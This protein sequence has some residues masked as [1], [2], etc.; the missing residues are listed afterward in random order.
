M[1]ALDLSTLKP[2]STGGDLKKAT[3]RPFIFLAPDKI[4]A[5]MPMDV[6]GGGVF[7]FPQGKRLARFA[8]Y[9]N[10]LKLTGNPNYVVIKPLANAPMGIFDLAKGTIVSGMN[11]ADVTLW[12]D[13]L[14]FELASGSVS[15]SKV[16][17]N[18]DDK[19]LHASPVEKI[20]IPVGSMSRLYAASISDDLHWLAAS[21][22]TRGAIWDLSSGERKIHV[23]GFRGAIVA[24]DGAAIGDFPKLDPINHSLVFLS[25]PT[26]EVTPLR[27]IPEKGSRQYGRFV[28]VR[29]S[30]KAPKVEKEKEKG[31]EG[32]KPPVNLAV[33]ESDDESLTHEVKFELRDVVN[34]KVIWTRE[35]RKEAPRYFFDDYSGRLIFYWDLGSEVG[36]ARLKED[37]A[38]LER[39]RQMGN[40]DDDYLVEVYDAFA[41]KSV[42]VLLLETGQ[43][44][45]DIES[46][47][48]E[49]DWLVLRDDNNRVL[50][51]SIN[52]GELR[53]RFFGAH[54]AMNPS[55]N[56][57]IVEN[58]PGELTLYDL[59]TGNAQARL[60][61]KTGAAFVRF[62]LDGKKLFVLTAGQV[63]HAFDMARLVTK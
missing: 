18:E 13:F 56:Q 3:R 12:N 8:L 49:G 15:V 26:N 32:D 36:K 11:K 27:E 1:L 58:Y 45:F 42:G 21:S 6:E 47:F 33:S 22:K 2:V 10:E 35:F 60:R 53:H 48:S 59:T 24:P 5:M 52:A 55:G 38:L 40:K 62:S 41:N 54:A 20:D 44:S 16:K 14:F 25:A 19:V 37:P 4:M 43:G 28:M 23:R 17:Y 31:K 46:G 30:F 61:F 51:Y 9:A 7:S 50:V 57:V 34:D 29:Q 63:A 39:S